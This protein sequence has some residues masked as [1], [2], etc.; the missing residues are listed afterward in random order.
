MNLIK[1]DVS[2][3]YP[4]LTLKNL[5][6]LTKDRKRVGRGVA[7]GLGKTCGRG[8]NG[9][10]SRTGS[11]RKQNG[12]QTPVYRRFPKTGFVSQK[13]KT[14]KAISV[15][16]LAT[17]LNNFIMACDMDIY[18]AYKIDIQWLREM[19]II[20]GRFDRFR[21]IMGKNIDPSADSDEECDGSV[22]DADA[23]AQN[24]SATNIPVFSDE[25]LVRLKKTTISASGFS[26]TARI[27]LESCGAT[28]CQDT[29]KARQ[30]MN[31]RRN[32][33]IDN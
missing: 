16:S 26:K 8:Y 28:L 30:K 17:H 3:M 9:A 5:T 14:Q 21:V 18:E 22:S 2:N 4:V 25:L 11:S 33:F 10:L 32:Q 15:E 12:G 20:K 1:K 29:G 24:V 19:K 6:K 31:A 7:S 13:N 23:S 27:F